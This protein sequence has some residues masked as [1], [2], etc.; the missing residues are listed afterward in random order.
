MRVLA[1]LA[2][3]LTAPMLRA[4]TVRTVAPVAPLGAVP[5]VA[6]AAAGVQSAQ[7]SLTPS[8]SLPSLSV[9][10]LTSSIRPALSVAPARAQAA[11]AARTAVPLPAAS[12]PAA[13]A[14]RKSIP[15]AVSEALG[16][17]PGGRG[18]A[19]IQPLRLNALF[20]GTRTVRNGVSDDGVS[21]DGKGAGPSKN[22]LQPAAPDEGRDDFTRGLM[23]QGRLLSVAARQ[24]GMHVTILSLL[25]NMDPDA[26][27]S[28]A[29]WI[30]IADE[31][32]ETEADDAEVE[33][34][35]ARSLKSARWPEKDEQGRP[36][37]DAV[38]ILSLHLKDAARAVT[39]ARNNEFFRWLRAGAAGPGRTDFSKA[40]MRQVGPDWEFTYGI[41]EGKSIRAVMDGGLS[42]PESMGKHLDEILDAAR[43]GGADVSGL[44]RLSGE[45]EAKGLLKPGWA[46]RTFAGSGKL[47]GLAPFGL[48]AMDIQAAWPILLVGALGLLAQMVWTVL[49]RPA[50]SEETLRNYYD[51]LERAAA[52]KQAAN[53]SGG[54][55]T[56]AT[57]GR[58]D[59]ERARRLADELLAEAH[60][61]AAEYP[62]LAWPRFS[63]AVRSAA[64]FL[65]AR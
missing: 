21:A 46:H 61:T 23:T 65:T 45:L 50:P 64:A 37:P 33:A 32:A 19:K 52:L 18:Q 31:L 63:R 5:G 60:E 35:F 10:S 2:V 54:T 53:P 34:A 38:S 39:I 12:A 26:S 16:V 20:D 56:F 51:K 8:L 55:P 57:A 1:T 27:L 42:T 13:A 40:R 59:P 30:K 36:T 24:S 48:A 9:P 29:D 17:K 15:Q 3:L 6:G 44:I 7:P 25:M 58:M 49:S 11:I 28:L 14:E 47:Y 4:Q 43:A 22:G 41:H 62:D